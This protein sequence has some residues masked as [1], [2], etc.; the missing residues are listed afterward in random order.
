MASAVVAAGMKRKRE[1]SSST[2][3]LSSGLNHEVFLN[4][5]GTDTR[6]EFTD[7][8]HEKLKNAGI[9]V[10]RDDE[11][12][13]AGEEINKGLKDAIKRSRISIAIFSKDYASSKSCLME[14][15]QMWEC[16]KSNGQIIIPIFYDV[17][18]KEVKHQTGDFATS[19]EKHKDDKVHSDTIKT[20]KEVLE[21]IVEL[22]GYERK[23]INSGHV[24]DLLE[25]VVTRVRQELTEDDQDV[26][27]K[28]VGIDLH[29]QEMMTKL[30]VVYSHGQA[31]KVCGEGVRVVGIC[32]MSGVGK[33][34]LAKVVFNKIHKLF[35]EC[36]FFKGINSEGVKVSQDLLIADLQN[37]KPEPLRPFG[38]GN[39]KIKSL[40]TN[41][42]VLIVLD[43]VHEDQQIEALAGKLTW[44]GSGSRI[45]VTTDN[46]DVLNVF[47]DEAV[48]KYKVKPM[49]NHHAHQ[50]F[51][52]H[53]FQENAPPD[54][55]EYDSLSRDIVKALG[56]LPMAIVLRAKF[57]KKKKNIEMWRSTRDSLKN[58]PHERKV[59]AALKASYE[60]LDDRTKEI[61]LDIACFFI[62]KDERIASYMWKACGYFPP[63]EIEELRD[64]HFLEDGENNE[65]RMHSLLR[66]FG[67]KLVE[68]N[69]LQER[70][71]IWKFS[72][73][74]SILM[75]GQSNERVQGISLLVEEACTVPFTCEKFGKKSKLRY[76]R[77][78]GANIV[79]TSENLLPNLK[80]LR[81]D[82][83]NIEEKSKE[84]PKNLLPNLRWLDWRKC[85]FISELCDVDLKELV[86]LDLSRNPVTRY[87]QVWRQIMEKVKE[88]KVLNLQGCDLLGASLKFSASFDLEMLI[89]EDCTRSPGLGTYISK[90]ERLQYLNLRNYK[91]VQQLLQ[92][93]RG[94]ELLTELLIDGTD[95]EEIHIENDSLKNLEVLS[96]RDCKKLK[97]ISP[98]GHLTKLKSLALDGANI[99]WV[100]KTFEFPQDLQTLSLRNC[101]MFE[102]LPPSIG[103]LEKLEVM[104]LSDT[105]I[106][107]LPESV[108]DLR[109]LKTLK[110]ERTHLQNFPEDIV[111]LK[112]LE[113]ID[114]SGCKSLVAQDSC[115]ISGLSS[116]RILRLSSS[117]VA[118]L[119]QG[120]CGL[121]RL[122]TLDVSKCERLQT[123]PELPSSLLTLCWGSKIMAAPELT[124]LTNLKELCLNNDERPEAGSSNPTPDI[125]WILG[126]TSLETF[127]LSLPNVTSLP[128]DFRALTQ[129]R[130]LTL[131]YMK[132]LVLTQLRLS[133]SLWTLRL[134]HCNIQKSNFSGLKYLSELELEDCDLAEIDGLE[135]L[136]LLEVLKI[137][138]CKGIT[139]LNGL[140]KIG[141]LR[142]VQVF[143]SPQVILPKLSE[144]VVVDR[145][146]H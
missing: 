89:M 49:E 30:G 13:C 35:D 74:R 124:N 103:K 38:K 17:T 73:A 83:T 36:S 94:K 137:S 22:V 31:M 79:G 64:M 71:R 95:I 12:L 108:K 44:L 107:E 28:L 27:D 48:E 143:S 56:G 59:E 11:K 86:I 136:T 119:P 105:R 7:V 47:D 45:I 25:N 140:K 21:K 18:P 40:F 146:D 42:K 144:R 104:D 87:S 132:E 80:Y 60:S 6:E 51:C 67:R 115:D 85:H 125:G 131:S 8:L 75:D 135:D 57:L 16:R 2:L 52:K 113:E 43:D 101:S 134:K 69:V 117:N 3:S 90:L 139:N 63:I 82:G 127:E 116:L 70:C 111:N 122:R 91:G 46:R 10:F 138:R 54:V 20:W 37:E 62:G 128:G 1:E 93:L 92:Q 97:D 76:L 121:S 141:C 123:L 61:F 98:I 66:D 72:D 126:L 39:K 55:P 29:V 24:T 68:K 129:L 99:D 130:E 96:A 65:L 33:T 118:G 81:L 58:H 32:G 114:F 145:C 142:M 5:R 53:V 106:T 19:F 23:N 9:V 110:M 133:R 41:M 26:I 34:T 15:V 14:L 109:N 100:P 120:I 102:E 78:D 84:N 77:L 112:K 50:L 4:F 88:L